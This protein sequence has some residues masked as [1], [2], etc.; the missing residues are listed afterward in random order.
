MGRTSADPVSKDRGRMALRIMLIFTKYAR[1]TQD[2]RHVGYWWH[3][4][5]RC[6]CTVLRDLRP[7]ASEDVRPG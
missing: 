7:L 5:E 1:E 3:I 2:V 4:K 6:G